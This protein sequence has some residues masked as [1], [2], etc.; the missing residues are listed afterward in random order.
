ML[1]SE[2]K[3]FADCLAKIYAKYEAEM[4]KIHEDTIVMS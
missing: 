4:I 2:N 3:I 1:K